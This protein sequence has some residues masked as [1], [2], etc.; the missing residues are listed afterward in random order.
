MILALAAVIAASCA[1]PSAATEAA[2]RPLPKLQLDIPLGKP[3][4]QRTAVLAGGCFWCEE[5]AFEQFSGVIGVVSGYAGGTADTATYERYHESNHAE[6]IQITYDASLLSYGELIRILFTAGDP[7]TKDGQKPD[8]GH[9]YRMAV[10]YGSDEE[11]RIAEAYIRQLT[12]A[13]VYAKPIEVTVEAMP[14]GFFPAE[15]YHQ[16]FVS[17]HPD[18]PYVRQWSLPKIALVRSAFPD[19]VKPAEQ[20][21]PKR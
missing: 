15:E 19:A 8:Y 6:V 18:H 16:G 3:G 12:E 7:T 20:T 2:T 10:F 1:G 9:Q 21:P 11:K 4:E 17:K 5:A 14:L 13:K